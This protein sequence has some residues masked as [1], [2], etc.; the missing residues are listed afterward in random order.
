MKPY[1][2][3]DAALITSF[4][5]IPIFWQNIANSLINEILTNLNEFSSNFAVSA[6]SSES[7]TST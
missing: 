2:F 1:G 6:T 5:S 7:Q 3:V 4:T